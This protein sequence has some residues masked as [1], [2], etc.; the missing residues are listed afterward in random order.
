[1]GTDDLT[2]M[3]IMCAAP[4]DF[5][6]THSKAPAYADSA[7]I[8]DLANKA[9]R[10]CAYME[11]FRAHPKIAPVC[12][13]QDVAN[14]FAERARG[15]DKSVKCQLALSDLKGSYPDLP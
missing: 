15:W 4:W 6:Y 2:L 10:F 8:L 14:K 12:M 11:R 7:P 5:L 13:K 3:D 1:M 9:P